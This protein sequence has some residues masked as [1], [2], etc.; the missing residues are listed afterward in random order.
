MGTV[1]AQC[2]AL[3]TRTRR[4]MAVTH[5]SFR[6]VGHTRLKKLTS[7]W[8]NSEK[9]QVNKRV[10]N[11]NPTVFKRMFQGHGTHLVSVCVRWG[12]GGEG[13][14][15]SVGRRRG[16]GERGGWMTR[17]GPAQGWT[18]M[19]RI[20][21]GSNLCTTVHGMCHTQLQFLHRLNVLMLTCKCAC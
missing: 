10:N 8:W 15:E 3:Q 20:Y 6:C 21:E 16:K 18:H 2:G 19:S 1:A 11:S 13:E 14:G 5:H 4:L 7:S 12:L 9:T 17:C